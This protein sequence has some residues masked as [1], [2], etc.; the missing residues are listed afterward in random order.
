VIFLWRTASF[1]REAFEVMEARGF[2]YKTEI[3]W[4]KRSLCLKCKGE[5]QVRARRYVEQLTVPLSGA[6]ERVY[7][8]TTEKRCDACGGHGEK[9]SFGMGR[10]VR[11][12]HE[13]CLIGVRGRAIDHVLSHSVRSAFETLE[14]CEI[15]APKGRH[16][17]KPEAFYRLV[18]TL[19]PGPYFELHARRTRSG[20]MSAGHQLEPTESSAD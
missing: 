19:F 3:A 9:D 13:V 10:I 16:S 1:A 14:E 11:G 7:D 12:S 4:F 17:E 15:V 8:G 6:K 5:G 20:W 18:E 2:T